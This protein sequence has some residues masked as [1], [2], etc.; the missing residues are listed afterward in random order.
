MR[1]GLWGGSS[2]SERAGG[3]ER[4]PIMTKRDSHW[5][6]YRAVPWGMRYAK[7]YWKSGVLSGALMVLG[8]GVSLLQPWPVAFLVDSV[9]DRKSH[10]PVPGLVA[11]TIGTNPVHLI[12]FAVLAGL[13]ITLAIHGLAV[14]TEYLNTKMHMRVVY[15]LRSHM[16][17]H[18]QKLSTTFHDRQVS[19]NMVWTINELADSLGRAIAAFLPMGQAMLMLVG[20]FWIAYRLDPILSLLSL[21]IV[22][23]VYYSIGYYSKN[24]LPNVRGANQAEI[25]AFSIIHE[26]ISMLRVVVAFSRESYEYQKYRRQGATAVQLRVKATFQQTLFSLAVQVF[27]GLG[28]ALV[29]GFGAYHVLTGRLSLGHLI[30]VMSYISA[31]YSPLDQISGTIG[32][33]NND[34]FHIQQCE[35]FMKREPEVKETKHA[36]DLPRVRGEVRY[37]HVD[38]RYPG[39]KRTLANIDFHVATGQSVAILGPTGAGKTTLVNLLVRYHD[40]QG[41][42]ILIDGHE[43]RHIKLDSLRRQI[44]MVLQE[45]LLFSGTVAD[46]IRYGRLDA[47]MREIVEAAAAANAHDFIMR[48]PER[49]ETPLGDKGAQL[50]GGERQRISIA[51]AFLKDAPILILD[52]PTSSIDS[53]TEAVILDALARLM[54]GRTTFLIA[55]RLSTVRNA[56]QIL[57]MNHGEIVESGSRQE[58]LG[59]GGLY[60]ELYEAQMGGSSEPEALQVSQIHR[61]D[62][63]HIADLAASLSSD[64]GQVAEEAFERLRAIDRRELMAWARDAI[65]SGTIEEA[66]HGARVAKRFGLSDLSVPLIERAALGSDGETRPLV[67]AFRSF[68]FAAQNIEPLLTALDP[69]RR[70]AARRLLKE[71]LGP[72]TPAEPKQ[73]SGDEDLRRDGV[74]ALTP[75][76]PLGDGELDHLPQQDRSA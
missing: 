44:S 71:V 63:S 20:M 40:P 1:R 4:G 7:P 59:R 53:K 29:I 52:E 2:G 3:D 73:A 34:F 72:D 64:D 33:L 9:L 19:G 54:E 21:S 65:R 49:Y 48:L 8:A 23:F 18:A 28:T 16:F 47:S 58:L 22:P 27:I 41:G 6:V 68:T 50:S 39:R 17:E 69:A 43:I 45:P 55:H 51:R 42:R 56:K 32:A 12:L 46:N 13:V 5:Q 25:G 10:K 36:I 37:E 14:A 31:I 38:F 57:V 60:A 74:R 66:R 35:K 30:V 11:T 61:A 24:V 67:D 75:A 26:A 15:D 62:A 70:P 76:V